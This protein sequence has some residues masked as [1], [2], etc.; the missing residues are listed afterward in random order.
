MMCVGTSTCVCVYI[1]CGTHMYT[2]HEQLCW[3][4]LVGVMIV[5]GVSGAMMFVD[6]VG[7]ICEWW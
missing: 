3:C 5:I 1:V 7:V 6:V 2:Y 4:W